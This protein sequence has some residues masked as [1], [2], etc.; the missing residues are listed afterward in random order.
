MTDTQ[1][2]APSEVAPGI[3]R[4]PLPFPRYPGTRL[5]TVNVHLVRRGGAYV[6]IDSGMGTTESFDILVAAVR[7][8]G[9]EPE[10]VTTLLT[11]HIHPDHYGSSQ[12]WRELSGARVL[13][14]ARDAQFMMHLLLLTPTDYVMFRKRHGLPERSS[15]NPDASRRAMR[16]FFGPAAPDAT[17]RDDETLVLG[18]DESAS[19]DGAAVRA[20]LTAGHTPGHVVGY[21]ADLEVLI[22]GDHL[23]P[24]ITP[25][26]GL[27]PDGLGGEDAGD[28]LG[29]Y[30][31]SLEKVRTLPVRIVCPSHGPVFGNHAHRVQQIIDHHRFRLRAAVDAVSRTPRTAWEVCSA[32]FGRLD[33]SQQD[34]ATMETLAHLRHL[35]KNGKVAAV[36]GD[37]PVRW[38]ATR[39]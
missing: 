14:H 36:D 16:D 13:L 3:F 7:S 6:L 19:A 31:E 18:G 15:E 26:I 12:R 32:I 1:G 4:I 5:R 37:A 39:D 10:Q 30:I 23:L 9:V 25:H 28:P 17:L 22:S 35:E 2:E 20:M 29:D 8:F 11:T 38:A 33:D 24:R 21:L 27:G 34:A